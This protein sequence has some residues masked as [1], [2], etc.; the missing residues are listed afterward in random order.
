MDALSDVEKLELKFSPLRMGDLVMLLEAA[1]N[2][3]SLTLNQCTLSLTLDE[4]KF[5]EL[6]VPVSPTSLKAIEFIRQVIAPAEGLAA[7]VVDYPTF[8]WE[9]PQSG[10][11]RPL[12]PL[13]RPRIPNSYLEMTLD[14]RDELGSI[15][16]W[17]THFQQTRKRADVWGRIKLTYLH[18]TPT[19]YL[20]HHRLSNV[21]I[22]L[23]PRFF[24]ETKL[25]RPSSQDR[26]MHSVLWEG[27]LNRP[28][29]A[30]YHLFD[31]IAQTGGYV[32]QR[33]YKDKSYKA[34]VSN[35]AT[36]EAIN[37]AMYRLRVAQPGQ[38]LDLD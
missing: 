14:S 17:Y 36:V 28:N 4:D 16:H 5:A 19:E 8:E 10:S 32:W 33:F 21:P 18:E 27:L 30:E 29:C 2:L 9:S 12:R 37:T 11:K 24:V 38:V 35:Q 13:L 7:F 25:A 22:Y 1:P 31:I 3:K 6:G 15:L 23:S 26:D 20:F 34:T